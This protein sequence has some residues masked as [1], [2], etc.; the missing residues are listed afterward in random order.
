ME[1]D[2]AHALAVRIN[3]GLIREAIERGSLPEAAAVLVGG[4]DGLFPAA[5]IAAGRG[6]AADGVLAVADVLNANMR[7]RAEQTHQSQD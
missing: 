7:A 3:I 1:G 5:V 6:D 2:A 4:L